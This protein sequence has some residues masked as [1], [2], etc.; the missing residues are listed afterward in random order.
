MISLWDQW[1][2]IYA[3]L[4]RGFKTIFTSLSVWALKYGPLQTIIL[5][6]PLFTPYLMHR[7]IFRLICVPLLMDSGMFAPGAR[8]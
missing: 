6:F 2:L 8:P 4:L 7:N 1:F 3:L 5:S